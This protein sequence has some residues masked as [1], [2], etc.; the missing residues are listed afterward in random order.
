ME[1]KEGGVNA[2]QQRLFKKKVDQVVE[3]F[4]KVAVSEDVSLEEKDYFTPPLMVS[5][6]DKEQYERQWLLIS[7]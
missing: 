7:F 6:R 5:K 3:A 4:S 1:G 2:Q